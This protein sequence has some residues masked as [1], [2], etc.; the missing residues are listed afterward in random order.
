MRSLVAIW[1][2]WWP[3]ALFVAVT[4][5]LT[6]YWWNLIAAGSV[7]FDWRIFVEA[8]ERAWAGSPT[9]YEVTDT[10]SFRHSPVFALFMPAIA[11]IGTFGVRLLTLAAAAALPTWPMRLL[12]VT[13]WPFAMDLQHG[14]L[15]T[16][17]VLA[18]A[19]SLRGSGIAALAFMLFAL[20]SPRPLMLP[21]VIFLLWR[22]PWLRVPTLGLVL[23]YV[24]AVLLTGY[25]DEW[26][27]MLTRSGLDM[28]GTPLNLSPSRLIGS[29]WIP[30]GAVLA[31]W[32]TVRGHPGF[33][34][35]AANPYV[36]PHYLLFALL[37]LRSATVSE[38]DPA[39]TT[40]PVA[41]GDLSSASAAGERTRVPDTP[42]G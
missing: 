4:S 19:W 16:L 17:L 10:Y 21:V 9:L 14:A 3:Y 28:Y 6:L 35:L 42:S 36:L 32:L 20:L 29:W 37:E 26:V 7:A 31:A 12:A 27:G 22:N 34:A 38:L 33:A 15:I 39:I 24:P 5:P 40:R 11:W 25:A 8:G 41:E 30:F 23:A 2:S 1:P 18:A 13:S